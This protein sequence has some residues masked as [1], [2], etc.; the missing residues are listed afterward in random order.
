MSQ[1]LGVIYLSRH[2]ILIR[3]K[4]VHSSFSAPIIIRFLKTKNIIVP[5]DPIDSTNLFD[6][7]SY[8][9]DVMF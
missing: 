2:I 6:F 7:M 8:L 9:I 3:L 5:M 4:R 1:V